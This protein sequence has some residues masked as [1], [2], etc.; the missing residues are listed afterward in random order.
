MDQRLSNTPEDEAERA[1]NASTPPPPKRT[2]RKK[3]A[4]SASPRAAK[5]SNAGESPAPVKPAAKRPR[6][7]SAKP[8]ANV[9]E[10]SVASLMAQGFSDGEAARLLE[11]SA[12]AVFSTE[13]RESEAVMNRLRF[14]RWLIERGVINE[15]AV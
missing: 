13:A 15:F 8:Q 6:A 4:S 12:R 9:R 3:S 1:A 14:T 10:E 2:R 11:L 7:K 5:P